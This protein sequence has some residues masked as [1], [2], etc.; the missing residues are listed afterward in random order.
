[1]K[2]LLIPSAAFLRDAKRLQKKDREA[3]DK[4]RFAL[5]VLE[6]DAFDP[7]LKTH[8]LSGALEGCWACTVSY[9]LRIV[10][11]LGTHE[12]QEALVLLAVGTHDEVY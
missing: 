1:V 4:L 8:K 9:D 12:G 6:D 2:R 5:N 7:R 3:S 10:F 11:E